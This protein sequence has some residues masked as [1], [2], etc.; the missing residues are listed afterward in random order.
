MSERRNEKE[1]KERRTK[2]TICTRAT[3]LILPK[4][5]PVFTLRLLLFPLKWTIVK[6]NFLNLFLHFQMVLYS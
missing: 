3:W 4:L 2:Y 6:D 1:K 5:I